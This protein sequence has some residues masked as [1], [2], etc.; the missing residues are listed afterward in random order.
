LAPLIKNTR[1]IYFRVFLSKNT[2]KAAGGSFS[3]IISL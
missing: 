1:N 2:R 3:Y